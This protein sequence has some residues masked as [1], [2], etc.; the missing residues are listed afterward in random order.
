MERAAT[1]EITCLGATLMAGL[2]IGKGSNKND[3]SRINWFLI[4]VGLWK[5]KTEVK[6]L[7]KVDKVFVPSEDKKLLKRYREELGVWLRAV[8][9]FKSWY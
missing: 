8:E 5:N 6:G 4:C 1:T 7:R 2:A 3:R 9:R